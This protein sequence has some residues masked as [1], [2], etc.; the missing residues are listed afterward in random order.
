MYVV[1]KLEKKKVNSDY[2]LHWLTLE[3]TRQRIKNSAQGS[4]RET[5]NFSDFG[6]IPIPLPSLEIQTHIAKTLNVA[7]DEID[8]LNQLAEQYRTQKRGLMQK[9]L[10]GEWRVKE[11]KISCRT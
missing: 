2:F 11:E 9:L 6:A 3:E 7:K 8:L 4:V 5:V 10:T 1:F